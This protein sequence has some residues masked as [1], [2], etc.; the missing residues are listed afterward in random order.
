MFLRFLLGLIAPF[1]VKF[2]LQGC[3]EAGKKQRGLIFRIKE[4]DMKILFLFIIITLCS[5]SATKIHSTPVD[6][7]QWLIGSWQGTYNSKPFYEAWRKLNDSALIN[8]TIEIKD[9]DTIVK[10]NGVIRKEGTEMVYKGSATWRL[11]SF[12]DTS[13]LF[14][15]D[16]L[17]YA[18]RISWTHTKDDH[19]LTVIKN[20]TNTITYDIVRINWPEYAID[21]YMR[22]AGR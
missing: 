8:F 17:R 9:G 12:T 11:L 18:N 7:M 19:W 15:N 13:M 1:A 10:E 2:F 4:A 3:Q 21:N 16:T 20:P 5:C 22:T 6:K 14:G